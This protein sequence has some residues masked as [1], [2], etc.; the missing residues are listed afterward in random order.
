MLRQQQ[1]TSIIIKYCLTGTDETTKSI[2][3]LA[4]L[5]PRP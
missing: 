2:T 3:G 5:G 1:K 4:A